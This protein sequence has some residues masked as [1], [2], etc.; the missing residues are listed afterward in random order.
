VGK[1]VTW[2]GRRYRSGFVVLRDNQVRWRVMPI[3]RGLY[4]DPPVQ[5]A[6][7]C[8]DTAAERELLRA[9]RGPMLVLSGR[10]E[11]RRNLERLHPSGAEYNRL[12]QAIG[13]LDERIFRI[14]QQ[15][16]D[17]G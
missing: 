12:Q 5:P 15:Q 13:A 16:Y 10:W 9:Q 2:Q 17:C 8:A 6:N 7:P 1:T 4:G 11:M 14:D 3:G